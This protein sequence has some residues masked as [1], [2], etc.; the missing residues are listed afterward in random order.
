MI[1]RFGLHPDP[2]K[3][4]FRLTQLRFRAQACGIKK[5]DAGSINGYIQFGPD[6]KI[7]PQLLVS[8]I[9]KA[10]MQFKFGEANQLRFVHQREAPEDKLNFMNGLLDELQPKELERP[11]GD[12]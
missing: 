12:K 8:L 10:P 2:L 4:L 7:D 3:L 6:T 5:L 11:D 9:Q 1:D